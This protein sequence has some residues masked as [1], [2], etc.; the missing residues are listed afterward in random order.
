MRDVRNGD[1]TPFQ[2]DTATVRSSCASFVQCGLITL[3]MKNGGQ[4]TSD[5]VVLL[6]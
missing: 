4:K 6:V 3:K 2:H 1:L 5:E